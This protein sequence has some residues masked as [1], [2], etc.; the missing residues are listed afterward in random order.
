MADEQ[1]TATTPE[2]PDSDLLAHPDVVRQTPDLPYS[3]ARHHGVLVL[4]TNVQCARVAYRADTKAWVLEEVRRF[5]GVPVALELLS[6]DAFREHL[7]HHYESDNQASSQMIA[8]LGSDLGVDSIAQELRE[9]E[10]LLDSADDAP[11]IR[12]INALFTQAV[13]DNASDIHIEPFEDQLI[14]RMRIDGVMHEIMQLPVSLAPLLVSRVK[15]MAHLD[16][17]EKRLPQDGRISLRVASHP[18]DIRVS[19]LPSSGGERVVLRLLDKNAGRIDLVKLGMEGETLAGLKKL[20]HKPHGILLVTG[21]TGSGKSTTLYAAI[22]ELNDRSMTIVTLEDPIEYYINGISQTQVNPKVELTFARGL[23]AILRQDP[24]VIMVGEIRDL[25]TVEVAIQASLTGH[26]VF[27]TLHTNSAIGA[28]TRLRDMGV[29][30]YL[31]SSSLIGVLAQRLIRLLCPACKEPHPLSDADCEKL[32]TTCGEH[33][34]D[35]SNPPMI[36]QPRGCDNCHGT[37]YSG[38]SGIYELVT[39]DEHLRSLIH[40]NASE[41]DITAYVSSKWR[42]LRQDGLRRVLDGDTSIDELLRVTQED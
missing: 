7:A 8:D 13:K 29:D 14:I 35:M 17:S 27:S 36:Y 42:N 11:I 19:T 15:V 24:D 22:D 26:L 6:A 3:F 2:A 5:L 38:R 1:V 34:I 30:S 21:P 28:L 33:G 12:L 10:D 37:G 25:E 23:R 4:N 32:Q 16:I 40:N 39:I 31:L 18:V 9:P 20:I 41:Q